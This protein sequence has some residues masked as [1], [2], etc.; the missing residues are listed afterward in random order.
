MGNVFSG[1]QDHNKIVDKDYKSKLSMARLADMKK[2]WTMD[3]K[4]LGQG[5]YGKVY[6]ATAVDD[7]SRVVAVKIINKKGLD[8]FMMESLENE[9]HLLNKV[10]HPHIAKYYETYDEANYLYMI[11]EFAPGGELYDKL[12]D[13]YPDGMDEKEASKMI[14]KICKAL[15][16]C[17]D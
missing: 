7:P 9:I 8:S 13:D 2:V 5:A 6:K 17:H 16:H 10:D 12:I 1:E 4:M 15:L 3:S 11:M 14:L